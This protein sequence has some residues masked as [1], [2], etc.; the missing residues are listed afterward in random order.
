MPPLRIHSPFAPA[1]DQP[2]AIERLVEGLRRGDRW[3]VLL[4]VTGSG[5]TFTMASVLE[6]L[7]RP[8][9]VIAHNKTLAGQ[10]YAEFS[11]FFPDNAV[12]FFVSYYDYYQPEAYVPQTDT[13]IEKDAS[14]NDDIDR[15]RHAA[16]HA[17]LTRRDVIIVASVS[18]LFGL[19]PVESYGELVV[20]LR[21][22]TAL[23]RD[24]LL[25]RLVDIHY[26]RNDTDF[27]R[28]TF[29][30][31][32]ESVDIFP[33]YEEARGLR[34]RFFGDEIESIHWIDALRG[35]SL[36][37]LE[38]VAVYPG[39]HY[40]TGPDQLRRAIQGI[41]QEL[42]ERLRELRST[43]RLLEAQRLEQR[44]LYDLESL[45]QLG[46]C[47]GIEN[48]SRHLSGRA[49]GEPP[50][51][52]IDYLA[53]DAVV[54]V[55]ES[56]QTLPQIQGMFKGDRSRK[57]N[58]VE[59]GFRLPSALDNR[60]LTFEEFAARIGQAVCVSA[61]PARQEI[62]LARGVVV[63]QLV[64]PTGL[65]DPRVEVRPAR[66]QVDDLLHEVRAAAA[67]GQRV[68]VTTLTKRMAEDLTEY[69]KE[70][71]VRVRYLHSDIDTLERL[72]VVRALRAGEFD[73]L[74]G[75]NLLREG[76]DI[77]EVALVAVLDADREGFLRSETSLIQTM[78]R[79]ARHV[80][81]RVILYADRRTES[82]ERA[83]R[84]TERRRRLQEE[85]NRAHGI[86]PRSVERELGPEMVAL[87][88]VAGGPAA[89]PAPPSR[90]EDL[91][92]RIHQLEREMR[93]AAEAL[94]FERAAEI[95]DELR[96]LRQWHLRLG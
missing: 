13:Y 60:P 52:L 94:E 34:V 89:A 47:A 49:P 31:R 51:T 25:R 39:S 59:F 95:R 7:Q 86:V 19:G 75:I 58:L 43:G 69:L 38:E 3:Q 64:R 55:D 72:Q 65:M 84:E 63:E 4:G 68:L 15:L 71:A 26:A 8:A 78:G 82:M 48:Y 18:C 57:E 88:D 53:A 41:R 16:T 42:G 2:E 76:L 9:L 91:V 20:R 77:P 28:G 17:L 11:R 6:R 14:I 62:E 80:L 22:G 74:V 33:A 90:I 44:T 50:P 83:L 10:L 87:D 1:G 61:T 70:H 40:V 24:E 30:V 29:R 85:F 45:E 96:A 5:K 79:A 23:P 92:E 66:D 32:G 56:H 46:Y 21:A 37:A 12:G 35:K 81:G 93:A 27:H 67:A 54:F 73:V 36:E